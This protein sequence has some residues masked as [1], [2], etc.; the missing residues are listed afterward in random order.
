[1]Q[2]VSNLCGI[3]VKFWNAL[4]MVGNSTEIHSTA[5]C[6]KGEP[7]QAVRVGHSSPYCLFGGVEVFG[8]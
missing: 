7:N 6:G 3:T 8:A 5:N 4:K 2:E 1:V